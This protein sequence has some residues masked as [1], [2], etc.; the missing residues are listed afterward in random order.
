[1][2]E[3][4]EIEVLAD[5]VESLAPGMQHKLTFKAFFTIKEV[6]DTF[7]GTVCLDEQGELSLQHFN[8]PKGNKR[9]IITLKN[10]LPSGVFDGVKKILF[11]KAGGQNVDLPLDLDALK[12]RQ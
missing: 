7:T 9:K 12:S 8:N 4:N 3:L 6:P 2:F 10:K 5:D 1:M 11:A